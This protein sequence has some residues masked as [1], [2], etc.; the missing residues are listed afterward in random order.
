LTKEEKMMPGIMYVFSALFIIAD[1]YS[2]FLGSGNAQ[3]EKILKGSRYERMHEGERHIMGIV[4]V[5]LRM[6]CC[7]F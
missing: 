4:L 6:S 7:F 1:C 3:L 5:V 2:F